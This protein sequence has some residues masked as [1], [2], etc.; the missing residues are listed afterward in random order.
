[1]GDHA[2]RRGVLLLLLLLLLAAVAGPTVVACSDNPQPQDPGTSSPGSGSLS[3]SPTIDPRAQEAVDAYEAFW[4]AAIEAE[5]HP[6]QVNQPLPGPADFTRHSW[7]PLRSD[8]RGY[9][10]GLALQGVAFEGTPPEPR[11]RVES[12][13]LQAK[14]YPTVVLKDCQTPA[15][16]WRSYV[17]ETGDEVPDATQS[18]P[19]PFEIT[20]TVIFYKERWGPQKSST[21]TSRTC[22]R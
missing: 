1:M 15:P 16:N 12:I 4:A 19:P 5:R 9:I 18:P 2:V 7:D 8:Y 14:P 22:K 10:G 17:V 13:D 20:V 11:V 21:D 3:A 6:V